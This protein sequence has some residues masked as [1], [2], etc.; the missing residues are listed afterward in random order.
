M[1]I[2][3]VPA[4]SSR[5]GHPLLVWRSS[6]TLCAGRSV[7]RTHRRHSSGTYCVLGPKTD[8]AL[9]Q[10]PGKQMPGTCTVGVAKEP[11]PALSRGAILGSSESV[12]GVQVGGEALRR[13]GVPKWGGI[14]APGSHPQRL[15]GRMPGPEKEGP[16][17]LR[18]T[19]V[20]TRLPSMY[21]ATRVSPLSPPT[22]LR[23]GRLWLA[24]EVG[25]CRRGWAGGWGQ[26]PRQRAV[27]LHGAVGL[28]LSQCWPGQHSEELSLVS[29]GEWWAA[30]V[31]A[32]AQGKVAVVVRMGG[33]EN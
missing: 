11:G 16:V 23:G 2:R 17:G 14:V 29:C 7:F 9:P 25:E 26:A 22:T 6:G 8:P 28:T 12:M 24:C 32:G 13:W 21:E 5:R 33:G 30:G 15:G 18:V 19:V 3:R 10:N 31:P 20:S 27:S 4:A 1:S